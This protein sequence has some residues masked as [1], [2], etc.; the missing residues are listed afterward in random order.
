MIKIN[1]KEL[2]LKD[3]T[4]AVLLQQGGYDPLRVAV[5][6]N[7]LIVPRGKYDCTILQDGDSLEIV[8]FVGGG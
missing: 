8:S 2:P 6:Q 7:G 1:G 4:V 3:I 5:E